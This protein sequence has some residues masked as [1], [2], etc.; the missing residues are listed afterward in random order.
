MRTITG[1]ERVDE[2]L[3]L[4]TNKRVGLITNP[5]GIDTK[6]KTSI[7]I[8][9]EKTNLV[10][11]F[12]PEHGIRGNL[13]AGVHL[14][15]Y[16]DEKTNATV[17]SLYGKTR[18]P[19]QEMMDTIDVLAMDIQEIGSRFYTYIYTMA[20]SMMACKEFDKEFVIFDRPG[21]IGT[22][23]CEGNILDVEYRSFVGYYPMLQRYGLTIGELAKMFNEEF[24]IGCKLHVVPVKN[25]TRD[26]TY[27]DTKLPWV[28]PSPNIPTLEAAYAYN[29]T[30]IFE[31][32]N[33]SEGRGTTKPFEVVGA[34]WIDGF[35]YAEA[36]NK[37]NLPAVRFRPFFFT[38]MFSKNEKQL[39]G[40]V[41]L[42]ISDFNAFKPVK[43]GWAMLKIVRDLYPNDF[44]IL[45]PY[46]PGRPCMLDYNTG[47]D[48][49]RKDLYNLP[50]LFEILEKDTKEFSKT[51]TKYF[52]Y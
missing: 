13:Q 24:E 34:P 47:G 14:E 48:F 28:A 51:R 30:C 39:C 23:D 40:G 49:I 25:Y 37:L 21:P 6:F 41:Q 17:F 4:F 3:N 27:L 15:T 42:H 1:I 16:V 35:E 36:L 44:K 18:K 32:T 12:S 38:P 52:I 33:L 20:Y 8:L 26:M 9:M 45:D 10:S 31:G 22:K 19:T 29:G 7:D 11:L 46:V 5:T 2:F 50:E 43:T